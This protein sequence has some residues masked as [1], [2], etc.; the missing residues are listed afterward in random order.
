MNW[1]IERNQ[2]PSTCKVCGKTFE[3]E[4][5]LVSH[6]LTSHPNVST[7]QPESPS[8]KNKAA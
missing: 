7:P 8:K 3:K 6:E 5:E 1:L 4:A 2:N